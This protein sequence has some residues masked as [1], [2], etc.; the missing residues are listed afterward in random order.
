M[1]LIK[2][3]SCFSDHHSPG[4]ID[5]LTTGSGTNML[6]QERFCVLASMTKVSPLAQSTPTIAKISPALKM[7]NRAFDF[8]VK[9]GRI[10][11]KCVVINFIHSHALLQHL[12]NYSNAIEPIAKLEPYVSFLYCKCYPSFSTF[13]DSIAYKS[14]GQICQLP[15]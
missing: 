2:N 14:I 7:T 13:P 12:P 6:S 11:I 5:I 10:E 8:D 3:F 15:V 1:Y 9:R 4:V